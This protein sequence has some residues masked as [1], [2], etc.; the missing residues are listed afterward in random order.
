MKPTFRV[1]IAKRNG[2]FRFVLNKGATK[3]RAQEMVA[4]YKNAGVRHVRMEQEEKP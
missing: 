4:V 1:I 2:L 3:E